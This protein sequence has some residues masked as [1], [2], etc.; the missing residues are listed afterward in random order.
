VAR[1]DGD[2]AVKTMQ[3]DSCDDTAPGSVTVLMQKL[4]AAG[5]EAFASRCK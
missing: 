5:D 4:S 2:T 1:E 3:A